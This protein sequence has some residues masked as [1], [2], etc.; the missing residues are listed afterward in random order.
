[1]AA[2]DPTE[3]VRKIRQHDNE[4]EALYELVERVGARIDAL[5]TKV[6]ARI[7]ALDTKVDARIDA[8]DTKVDAGFERV[9]VQLIDMNGKLDAI[10][11]RL[12]S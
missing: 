2:P 8:L 7:D 12:S 4:F 6:D 3:L 5:D 1:M 10:L 11:Q 9:D